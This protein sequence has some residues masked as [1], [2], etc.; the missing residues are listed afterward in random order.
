MDSRNLQSLSLLSKSEY[1]IIYGYRLITKQSV[2]VNVFHVLSMV[3]V[4]ISHKSITIFY[5][6]VKRKSKFSRLYFSV[7]NFSNKNT[8]N[9]LSNYNLSAL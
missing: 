5:L 2:I 1:F 9:I 4:V 7:L 3:V 6:L 8:I